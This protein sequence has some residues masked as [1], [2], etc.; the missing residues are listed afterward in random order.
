MSANFTKI[1]KIVSKDAYSNYR[2]KESFRVLLQSENL[3]LEKKESGEPFITFG[4]PLKNIY[5]FLDGLC[6]SEKYNI[7][8]NLVKSANILPLEIF[9]LF[10]AV[11]P[12]ALYQ[13]EVSIRCITDCTFIKVPM[14]QYLQAIRTD[15]EAAWISIQSL[16]SFIY[17]ILVENDE[18]I[19]NDPIYNICLKLLEYGQTKS[20]PCILPYKKEELAQILNINLRTLYRKLDCLYEENL[21]YSYKGKIAMTAEQYQKIAR[22]LQKELQYV[23]KI[24]VP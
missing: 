8:G 11:H 21:I 19:L 20:F 10:E 6:C 1:L 9:G 18:L 16:S 12:L 22:K 7:H 23:P 2:N 24:S 4:A 15:A 5:I 13:H 17:R 3:C 14:S